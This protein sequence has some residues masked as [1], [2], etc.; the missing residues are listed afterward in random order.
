MMQSLLHYRHGSHIAA[1]GISDG[2][3]EGKIL[4]QEK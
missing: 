4:I 3:C 1:D 2:A